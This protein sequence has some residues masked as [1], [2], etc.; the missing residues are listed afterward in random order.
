MFKGDP[1]GPEYLILD[2]ITFG[3]V[4]RPKWPASPGRP[5]SREAAQTLPRPS[6][7]TPLS[8]YDVAFGFRRLRVRRAEHHFV[9]CGTGRDHRIDVL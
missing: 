3:P 5:E 4:A 6:W 9:M 7:E 2:E 1:G 8:E